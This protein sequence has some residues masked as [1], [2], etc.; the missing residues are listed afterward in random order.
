VG[1]P[2]HITELVEDYRQAREVHEGAQRDLA[3]AQAAFVQ[4][5]GSARQDGRHRRVAALARTAAAAARK[6]E[7]ETAM[8]RTAAALAEALALWQLQQ[9]KRASGEI[10]AS[11]VVWQ[12]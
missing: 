8:A 1:V 11:L 12:R 9:Q 4:R 5:L 7:A 3:A 10:A 2:D 6:A